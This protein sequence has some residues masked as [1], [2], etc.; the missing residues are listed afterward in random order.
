MNLEI[1]FVLNN[2]YKNFFVSSNNKSLKCKTRF[3]DFKNSDER[4]LF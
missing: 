4:E 1:L 2:F 3:T